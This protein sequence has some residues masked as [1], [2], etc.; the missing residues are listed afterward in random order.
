MQ[1]TW[2]QAFSVGVDE[3]DR[4]H[5]ELFSRI[6]SL[7]SALRQG[8]AKIEILRLIDFLDDYAVTHFAL[9]EGYMTA[10][11]Y[12]SLP[13]HQTEH[14]RFKTEFTEIKT[15]FDAGTL[16]PVDM[17]VRCSHLLIDWFCN[18]IRTVDMALGEF[19]KSKAPSS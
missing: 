1:L 9:E 19:L 7:H 12:P 8:K 10:L 16:L 18:H 13:Q 17:I 2:T 4:Q 11:E 5:Q 15:R 14:R 3:I 6:N